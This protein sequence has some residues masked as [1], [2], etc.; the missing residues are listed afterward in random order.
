VS[1]PHGASAVAGAPVRVDTIRP[2]LSSLAVPRRPITYRLSEPARV[3]IQLQRRV[4]GRWRAVRTLRQKG[5][6]GKNRLRIG[7]HPPAA[8]G[9]RRV[10]YRAE[11]SAVDAVGTRSR[12]V[13]LRVSA[14]AAR[15]I[16]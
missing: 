6:A 9:T 5:V 15:R 1:D 8:G 12:L 2:V 7:V 14:A 4:K 13:R 16:Q 3:R 11:A 10:R